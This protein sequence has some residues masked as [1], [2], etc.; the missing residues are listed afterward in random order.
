M[1]LGRLF[2]AA[3]R[4]A[5]IALGMAALFLGGSWLAQDPIKGPFDNVVG[6][7]ALGV[8]LILFIAW[9]YDSPRCRRIGL[10]LS[11]GLWSSI[12]SI[13]FI[14]LTAW[15]SG[16]IALAW[17]FLAGGSYWAEVSDEVAHRDHQ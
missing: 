5:T 3:F 7:I 12:A 14:N 1:T 6:A 4:P 15:T 11:V 17:A 8:S 2:H 9:G 13:A 10:L 16:L